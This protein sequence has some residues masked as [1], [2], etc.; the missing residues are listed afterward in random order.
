MAD[1]RQIVDVAEG[2]SLM[3]DRAGSEIVADLYQIRRSMTAGAFAD[4]MLEADIEG[5]LKK[6]LTKAD[7]MFISGHKSVLE[8]T[9]GF[10]EINP[11]KLSLFIEFNRDAFEKSVI[12]N[13]SGTMKDTIARGVSA[14]LSEGEIALMVKDTTLTAAQVKTVVNTQLNNYSRVVTNEMMKVAPKNAK[15]RYVGPQDE[16][17]RPICVE[18]GG[19]GELTLKELDASYP[20]AK[21]AGGGYNCRHKWEI[22]DV[23]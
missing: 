10:A 3:V 16:K 15:Y 19:V 11:D 6:K 13:I 23:G 20:S 17:T 12:T 7:S 18:M 2:I 1:Q 8:S 21:I 5:I 14:G 4:L 22:S 9:M